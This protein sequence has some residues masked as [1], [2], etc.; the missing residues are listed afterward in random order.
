MLASKQIQNIFDGILTLKLILILCFLFLS[1]TFLALAS[2]ARCGEEIEEEE[3]GCNRMKESVALEEQGG[4][5]EKKSREEETDGLVSDVSSGDEIDKD[6][7]EEKMQQSRQKLKEFKKDKS[8]GRSPIEGAVAQGHKNKKQLVTQRR[9]KKIRNWEEVLT[10]DLVK[11]G[12]KLEKRGI[13]L[14]KKEDDGKSKKKKKQAE[15]KNQEIAKFKFK[16][17]EEERTLFNMTS[18][19]G[20]S[21]GEQEELEIADLVANADNSDGSRQSGC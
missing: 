18:H 17:K 3:Q 1:N 16:N 19:V 12:A 9:E 8:G 4:G 5:C 10:G 11:K 14:E 2:N 6:V 21:F 13:E 20:S 15:L 7:W